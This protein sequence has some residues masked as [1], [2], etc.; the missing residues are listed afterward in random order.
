MAEERRQS[1]AF[2]NAEVKR[3]RDKIPC[4]HIHLLYGFETEHFL[5]SLLFDNFQGR[6]I[7]EEEDQ[8]RAEEVAAESDSIQLKLAAERDA[9]DYRRQMAEE[10][11]Q[12]YAYRNE[13]GRRQ[14]E[15]EEQQRIDQVIDESES[16]QLKLAAERDADAYRRQMAAR[17]RAS[18]QYRNKEGRIHRMVE[19][20]QRSG[21]LNQRHVDSKLRSVD[22]ASIELARQKEKAQRA[23]FELEHQGRLKP[24]GFL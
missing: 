1:Y 4:C 21:E 8:G 16:I 12:S 9:D 23:L 20:N 19:A 13:E 14:R 22:A 2:R 6:R 24:F 5:S 18:L 3:H 7:R 15:E 10:R 11:R 17:K